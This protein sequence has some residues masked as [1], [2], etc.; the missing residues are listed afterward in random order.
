MASNTH[1]QVAEKAYQKLLTCSWQNDLKKGI[2]FDLPGETK[3]SVRWMEEKDVSEVVKIEK[4][5][6]PFPWLKEGFLYRLGELDFN[7]SLVGFIQNK[8]VAYTVSYI[9]YDELHFDNLAV[10]KNFR[11][12]KIGEILLW[13]SLQTGNEKKCLW[14]FLEVRKGNTQ[15]IQLYKKFGFEKLGVRKKY[16]REENEDALLMSKCIL[17]KD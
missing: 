13:L 17:V 5:I 8:L 11:N 2:N 7:V 1:N 16:Y 14:S 4:E 6:F 15:A 10:K 12:N 3:L 9:V